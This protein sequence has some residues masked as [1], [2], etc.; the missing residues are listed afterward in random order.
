MAEPAKPVAAIDPKKLQQAL[1]EIANK[2]AKMIADFVAHPPQTDPGQDPDALGLNKAFM[3]FGS[4]LLADP[5]RLAEMQMRAWDDHLKLWN[6]TVSRFLGDKSAPLK[7][8]AKGDNRFRGDLWQSNL[9]FDYIKQ[10]YLIASDHMQRAVGE[11]EGLDPKAA[12]KVKFFTRQYI[13]ALAPTNFVAT[14]PEVL[15]AT[16][17][18]GGGNLL[19]GLNH[20]L[21]DLGRGKGKL[22]IRMTD[23]SAFSMGENVATT[24]GKVVFQNDLMQLLQFEPT[25]PKVDHAPLLIVPPWINKYYI[26]DLRE[27]NSFIRW[28]TAQGLTVFVISW[29]NPDERH[30]AKTFHDYLAQG[31][32][33]AMDAIE[34]ATGESSMNLIGY[35]LGGTLTACLAS[36][37]Q[38][39]GESKRVRS[40]TFFTTMIDFREPGELGVF[41]DEEI[42]DK[43]EKRMAQ[44]G[45]L[46]GSDMAGTFNMLRDNDLIWSFVV[47]NYLLGKDPF[48]FDLLYWNSDA[49]RMPAKMHT[50]YL[51][52]MYVRNLLAQPGALEVGGE[53]MDLSKV[54]TPACFVSTV[55]D[56]IAP[57]KSTHTGAKL[58][59]GPVRFLLGGS[60]HIAGIVNPPV[61]KKYHYFTNDGL[62][63]DADTWLATANRHEGSWWDDWATWIHG[64]G[65]GQVDARKPGGGRLKILEDAPGSYAKFRLDAVPEAATTAPR[66]KPGAEAETP[67]PAAKP[68]PSALM[69]IATPVD[70]LP[71]SP[72]P[73]RVA[74]PK[75]P[76]NAPVVEVVAPAARRKKAAAAP[77]PESVAP[78]IPI[79]KS[80]AKPAVKPAVRTAP[81][82]PLAKPVAT[83]APVVAKPGPRQKPSAIAPKAPAQAPART[84]V[85]V[86]APGKP[87]GAAAAISALFRSQSAPAP[88]AA[89]TKPAK[90]TNAG[91]KVAKDKDKAG[92][93]RREQ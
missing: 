43:L 32:L 56:H 89:P 41:V 52:N 9:V 49:T 37:L 57:W 75:P 84:A 23:N 19:S 31:P 39:R 50:F 71:V 60:G 78:A 63:A 88:A 17:D 15:K 85:S 11:V 81:T 33:A 93:K 67:K 27:S 22:A 14:N 28:A 16:L 55:E 47:N 82:K 25:T 1:A 21:N 64:F 92:G 3:D 12:R 70:A 4:R 45:F 72:T 6:S 58:L 36:W 30:A 80:A 38:A 59:G 40:L 79:R 26:L 44:R 10:S 13:N 74:R 69:A 83:P 87:G 7:E 24:P 20:L 29:V 46:E 2:S 68:V 65:G 73:K 66:T 91:K 8:P 34:K 53:R 61:A 54:V 5:T 90:K 48:P 76:P 86:T 51:R 62:T 18:S 77:K 35:C 42:V